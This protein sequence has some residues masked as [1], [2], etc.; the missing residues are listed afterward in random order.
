MRRRGKLI[1]G[2][3]VFI[4]IASLLCLSCNNNSLDGF[5]V[6][7]E[8]PVGNE[9]SRDGAALIAVDPIKPEKSVR[10]L[11][12]NFHAACEPVLSNNGRYL[13][14]SGKMKQEDPWQIWQRDL[15]KKI[16]FQGD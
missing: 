8:L 3:A 7:V 11:S 15:Q 10:L 4:G 6:A 5:I 16:H 14:F 1:Y 2:L 12:E 9:V 13:I